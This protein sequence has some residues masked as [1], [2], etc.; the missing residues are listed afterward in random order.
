MLTNLR[1]VWRDFRFLMSAPGMATQKSFNVMNVK[2]MITD[3][4]PIRYFMLPLLILTKFKS[5]HIFLDKYCTLYH[6][7]VFDFDRMIQ[8]TQNFEHFGKENG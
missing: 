1:N 7:M 5:L 6:T 3:D 8:T 4:V 2:F